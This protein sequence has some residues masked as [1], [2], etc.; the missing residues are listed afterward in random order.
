MLRDD[1]PGGSSEPSDEPEY[2]F[3]RIA[4]WHW[5]L[6]LF[7]GITTGALLME[8]WGVALTFL[9]AFGV[10]AVGEL[11]ARRL[12]RRDVARRRVAPR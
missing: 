8:G 5:R 1:G 2:V 10:I 12:A 6:R 9:A 7:G 4:T 3:L 11:A